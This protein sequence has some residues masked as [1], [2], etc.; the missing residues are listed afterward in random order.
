MLKNIPKTFVP[1]L[2]KLMMQMGHGETLLICDSNFPYL[3]VGSQAIHITVI[4]IAGLLKDIL[5]FF[6]LDKSVDSAA[7]VM[8]SSRESGRFEEYQSIL[9]AKGNAT[10]LKSEGRFEFYESARKA[11]GAVITSDTVKG[12]NIIIQ[13][14]VVRDKDT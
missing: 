6:P 8:E 5:D 14:G 3:S 7:L 2:M 13:K 11:V 4:S 1:D 9:S 12:G 10:K